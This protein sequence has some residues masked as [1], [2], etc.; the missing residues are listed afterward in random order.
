MNRQRFCQNGSG[1]YEVERARIS[2]QQ[3]FVKKLFRYG[4]VVTS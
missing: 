4:V 1:K 3:I 2:R